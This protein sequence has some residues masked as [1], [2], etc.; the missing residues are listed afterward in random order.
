MKRTL[1]L[2][3]ICFFSTIAS[4]IDRVPGQ[5][6]VKT[7]ESQRIMGNRLGLR[8]LDNYLSNKGVIAVKSILSRQENKYFL[9]ETESEPDWDFLMSANFPGVSYIQPNYINQMHFI[10]NDQY[11]YDQQIN[12]DNINLP[13]AWNYTT[14]NA[15]ILIAIIDSGIHFQ[16]PDLQNNIY[17]NTAEI[18]DDNI[19]NDNN[20]YIDDWHGW[21]FTDAP[22]LSDIALGDY[23]EQ[24]N[25]PADD[26]N[27]G[28]HIAGIIAAD[29]NNDQ[30]I[31]GI[32]WNIEML[33]IRAGFLTTS[34][35]GFLQDDDAA[36]GIIYAADMGADVINISWGDENYSPIIEDACE[37]A[38]SQ[39]SIIVAS[40]GNNYVYGLMYPAKLSSTIAVGSVDKFMDKAEFSSYGPELD[41]VAPGVNVLSTYSG[42][43]DN[44]YFEQSGTSMSAPFVSAALGLLFSETSGMNFNEVKSHLHSTAID[45]GEEGYDVEY[46][47]GLI[48]VHALLNLTSTLEIEIAL[49]ADFSGHSCG[50]DLIGTV[51]AD[52]FSRYNVMYSTTVDPTISDWYDINY[53]HSNI[54]VNYQ[55]EVFDDVIA[56][57]DVEGLPEEL[58]LY[59]VKIELITSDNKHFNITRNFSIDL[60][61][62]VFQAENSEF[63]IRYN[64]E[65]VDNY[66]KASF[67]EPVYLELSGNGWG[68]QAGNFCDSLQYLELGSNWYNEMVQVSAVNYCGL[69]VTGQIY[70]QAEEPDLHSIDVNCF[71]TVNSFEDFIFADNHF[72]FD[73]NGRQE[74]WAL[75]DSVEEQV[76][77]IYEIDNDQLIMKHLFN[78]NLWPHALGNTNENGIEILGLNLDYA[79]LYESTSGSFYP[80]EIIWIESNVYGGTFLNYDDDE[81]DEIALVKNETINSVTKRVIALYNRENNIITREYLLFNDTPASV[82]NTFLNRIE[83]ADLNDNGNINILA[84]DQDGDVIIY[85][86]SEPADQFEMI[87]SYRLPVANAYY[88]AAGDLTGDG[89]LEFCAGGYN[90]DY[91]DPA[92]TFSSFKFFRYDVAENDFVVFDQLEFSGARNKNSL[93]SSDLDGDNDLELILSLPPNAYVVDYIDGRF[94]P[95]WKGSSSGDYNNNSMAVPPGPN[96]DSYFI[97]NTYDITED[98]KNST[99]FEAFGDFTGPTTPENFNILPLNESSVQLSWNYNQSADHFNIYKKME[100]NEFV[101]TSEINSFLDEGLSAGDSIC[102]RITAVNEA[103]DPVESLPTLW[104]TAVTDYPPGLE[105]INMLSLHTL[106]LEFDR[107][108]AN[109]AAFVSHYFVSSGTGYPTAVNMV[110]ENTEVILTFNL[111]FGEFD[112]YEITISGLTGIS[113]VKFPDGTYSFLFTEDTEPPFITETKVLPGNKDIEIY[114]NESMENT[115]LENFGNYTLIFPDIDQNNF[116]AGL[117][118]REES[119]RYYVLISLQEE[120]KYTNQSYFLKIENAEDI[121]GNKLANHGNKCRF[122]L[123][124]IK[125]LDY[126]IVYPNPLNLNEIALGGEIG[127]NFINLPLEEKGKIK[128]FD[129]SGDLVFSD[130][131]GPYF[132]A[133]DYYRWNI[134]NKSGNKISSGLYYYLIE[135]AGDV[136]KGKLVLIN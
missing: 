38:L 54:P 126:L 79:Y 26:I 78:F 22:N 17:I 86:Y 68:E 93:L 128:I 35:T 99:L 41:V 134:R 94:K 112:E 36:A 47:S 120:M 71:N 25:D 43:G 131:F 19:D 95:V 27:H 31:S 42:E 90:I 106:K 109:S 30:G 75:T 40:S 73:N 116:L 13:Q 70:P 108:L 69:P 56:H 117:E 50:F 28:T 100:N 6:I 16:H 8:D 58:D 9:I 3:L 20:G 85:E 136:K 33:I 107:P 77:A 89:N 60:T 49:P 29:T 81:Y 44:L 119:T 102:Y 65:Y 39:G 23:L 66:V 115:A 57:F 122:S 92:K 45:L 67:N 61:E 113:G 87:W 105:A 12:F 1:I 55:D 133:N 15:E 97:L 32:C 125:N 63:L 7:S 46:G 111:C 114:F 132:N 62:P 64:G 74:F 48:D 14:G 34:G 124:D 110:A 59:T 72:D 80:N 4:G 21:D 130:G 10:P 135:I 51:A 96:E 24:D 53:P 98:Q 129:L 121:S 118:Y 91:N 18:P 76:S 5:L 127:F 2:V 83:S 103:F 84:S 52:N 37:Y 11:Y 104:K 101:F 82:K 123:T 88:L